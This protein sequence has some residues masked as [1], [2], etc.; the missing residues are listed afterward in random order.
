[1]ANL[2]NINNKFI[3]EDSG[4]VGIGVTT[5][6]TKL[7]I[8]GTAPG[9]SIIRQD[10]TVSGTNWEI[11][12]R[13]AGKWQI[14][15]DDG[16]TIVATFMSSGN[17]GIGTASPQKNL[18]IF[19][20]EGGVGVK[21][22]TIRLGGYSTVGPDIAAYRVTGNSNDQGLIFS[23]YDATAGTVDTMTLTNDGNVGIGTTTPQKKLHI[24][25]TGGASEMQILVSSAS[26]TVGHTA[27]IGLRGEGGEADGD[28]RIKGGIFF[29]R[30]AGSFGNGKMILA[31]NS[32]VSNTSVTVAD[33]A[34]TIDT[35]K[36]VGIGTASPT[37]YKLVI[38][39]TAEDILKLHNSTDGLDS[40][41]SF[42]NPG[43]TLARIQGL[44]N[45]GLQFD[46][47]NNAGGLNTNVM[48]LS[49]SGNV[50]IGVISPAGKLEVAGGSTLGLRLSN[51][52]DQSAYDQVRMTYN[53]YNGGAPTV[54]FMPLTT[55]GSGNVDT[56]FHFMNTNGLNA[57]NNRANVNIDGILYVGSGRQ[58]GETTLI[59]R[60]Y[61]DTLV[62]SNNI[63]N[64]IR[65]S[66]RY[67]SGSASQL[68]E[69]RIN[70]V[71]QESNGNG[72]SALTFWTQ[73][74][75]SAATEQMRIDKVGNVGIG[76]T[77]TQKLDVDGQMTH[78]GLVMK[79]GDG[80]Y[81]D[82][83]LAYTIN[84][85][86][87]AFNW[88]DTGIYSNSGSYQLGASGTY[89]VQIY[90]NSHSGEPY[91]YDAYWSGIMSW[92]QGTVNQNAV[93][94]IPL[95]QAAHSTNNRPLEL[96]IQNT[97]GSGPGT[98]TNNARLEVKT[99]AAGTNSV[100]LF[101]RFRRLI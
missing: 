94:E 42:T 79:S 23:T 73:T 20:A 55:P 82:R 25:G 88:V 101:F 95:T 63:Q 91:W 1:M 67:W 74:G 48:Y 32:S 26:D 65:M 47:G 28:F 31:V 52:G 45:G 85:S 22:A 33:H 96:R 56:T 13:A 60:N 34:L 9:D 4:D 27:G 5:A 10:S 46:T 30:I 36:N 86:L 66:G 29:E 49:N 71:H 62:D 81:I 35:N 77:P 90:S 80:V 18:Q 97:L 15:E 7:H 76:V 2:S 16:D 64:S 14:F 61:D 38:E 24:E 68:I 87:I 100:S 50:G 39:N 12:E 53:G 83:Y 8:G 92:H 6:T 37:G 84:I 21:H 3:V 58:S 99:T 98:P 93:F 51:V 75:G 57:S 69:T 59:M 11:G 19:Q 43:G 70:S 17:V 89:A 54:T 41:I 44:D 78:D 72:G 40:L